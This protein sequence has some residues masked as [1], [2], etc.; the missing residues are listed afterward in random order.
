MAWHWLREMVMTADLHTLTAVYALTMIALV[1]A[2]YWQ[3][4]KD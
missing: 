2:A 1:T 4:F 3:V